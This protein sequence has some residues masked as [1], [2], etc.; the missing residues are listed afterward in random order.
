MG[1]ISHT[2]VLYTIMVIFVFHP[3][4]FKVWISLLKKKLSTIQLSSA[5]TQCMCIG[6]HLLHP[7]GA[8]GYLQEPEQILIH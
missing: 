2:E 3:S 5:I 7:A 6:K 1:D 4:N 8:V